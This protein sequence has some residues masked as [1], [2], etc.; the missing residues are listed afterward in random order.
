MVGFLIVKVERYIPARR[1]GE[2]NPCRKGLS[3]RQQYELM[4]TFA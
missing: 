4:F 2:N 3:W 1:G